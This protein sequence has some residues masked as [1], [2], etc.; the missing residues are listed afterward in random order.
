M[1]DIRSYRIA[2]L[3]G[4]GVVHACGGKSESSD[5]VRGLPQQ[6]KDASGAALKPD[7]DASASTDDRAPSVQPREAGATRSSSSDDTHGVVEASVPPDPTGSTNP[8][9]SVST[10][11]DGAPPPLFD[12]G[13]PAPTPTVHPPQLEAGT[14]SLDA[15]ATC[16][17]DTLNRDTS[18]GGAPLEMCLGRTPRAEIL[19]PP[20]QPYAD[21]GAP[22]DGGKVPLPSLPYNEHDPDLDAYHR[23]RCF[24]DGDCTEQAYGHC[25]RLVN[26]PGYDTYTYCVYGCASDADCDSDEACDCTNGPGECVRT[27]CHAD[28]DCEPCQTC[29]RYEWDD[30]CGVSSGF[31]CTSPTDECTS[32]D[33]CPNLQCAYSF[34]H[35]ICAEADCIVGRPFLVAGTPRRAEAMT[36]T[37]WDD[38]RGGAPD[39]S[40]PS[41]EARSALHTHWQHIGLMEHASVAAFA[42]FTLQLLALGAPS[43]LV[44]G[45]SRAMADEVRHAELAFGL[46]ARFGERVGPGPLALD[47]SLDTCSLEEVTVQTLL[48]GCIGE[49]VAAWEARTARDAARDL[50]VRRVLSQV[51]VDEQRHA[52]LAWRFVIWAL[53]R[54]PSLAQRLTRALDETL[55][56]GQD[57]CAEIE[58]AKHSTLAAYGLLPRS[59]RAELRQHVLE[60]V[61]QPVLRTLVQGTGV[62]LAA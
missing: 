15:S 50:E 32:G 27:N 18:R 35:R 49:T 47:G 10:S 9:S 58:S 34:E 25:E 61:V 51:A 54:E 3:A 4:L 28:A 8:E 59:T 30:G 53:E 33:E 2:L 17:T 22:S 41:A 6:S 20:T 21:A 1:S 7:S 55:T 11:D 40:G 52:D 42:R 24:S 16:T 12:A 13:E 5:T 14:P 57:R 45:A 26:E 44:Q 48:E 60:E 43:Q 37:D 23:Y 46:A 38:A 29:E 19:Y 56:H 62:R 36:R 39:R 31:A